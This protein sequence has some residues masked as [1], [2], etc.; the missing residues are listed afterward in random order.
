MEF[1]SYLNSQQLQAVT[2]TDGPMLILA[3]AGSG[4]TRVITYKIAYLIAK[5]LAKPEEIL[6]LTFTNKAAQ[7]MKERACSLL[8]GEMKPPWIS[9]FHALGARLLRLHIDKL[10]QS[11]TNNFT[12]YNEADQVS[13]LKEC[14]QE[15]GSDAK[16][17]KLS[18]LRSKISNIKMNL[19]QKKDSKSMSSAS[20]LDEKIMEIF[21][22]YQQ[23][24]QRYNALD[25][26]DLLLKTF[27]LLNKVKNIRGY[28]QKKFRYV[29]VD[30]FQDT[31]QL[32]YAMLKILVD[33]W[34]NICVVG[35][36]D[37]SIY[38]WRG[39]YI[40]NMFNFAKDFPGCKEIKL[41][42]NYRSTK[43]ILYIA[44]EVIAKNTLRKDKNLW[45]EREEGERAWIYLTEDEDEEARIVVDKIVSLKREY[46]LQEIAVLY[47]TNF[48]SRPFEQAL[49]RLHLPY[50]MVGSIRFFERK[51]IKDILSYFN[52]VAEPADHV[53][54]KRIINVPPRGI[55]GKTLS[56]LEQYAEEH[57]LSLWEAI[58]ADIK[59]IKLAQN[60]RDSL[61]SLHALIEKLRSKLDKLPASR[62]LR[63]IIEET[64]YLS[65]FS[66]ENEKSQQNRLENLKELIAAAKNYEEREE[67]ASIQG[68]LDQ[69]HLTTDQDYY[70][71]TPTVS[72]MTLHCA[73]GLEFSA[74]FLVGMVEG[75]FPH[76]LN[77]NDPELLEEERRLCYVGMTRAKDKLFISTY[78]RRREY[79]TYRNCTPSRFLVDI[80]SQL[81]ERKDIYD[82]QEVDTASRSEI[83]ESIDNIQNFFEVDEFKTDIKQVA[84]IDAEANGLVEGCEVVHPKYG[85]GVLFARSGS[86]DSAKVSVYFPQ[87]GKKKFLLKYAPL[88][89][90]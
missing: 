89:K 90:A 62:L 35:D 41:Q 83:H 34:R 58:S 45:T 49:Q 28:Y 53:S 79:D 37:Q 27:E 40:G 55:G 56:R 78:L 47:R 48:Q 81:I 84:D 13:L 65:T 51:E 33:R 12:I 85:K 71:D 24:L 70:N 25:F 11:L 52:L 86:G 16:S 61:R 26:D 73:K 6:A 50:K 64:N 74:V 72:L 21:Q 88:K 18:S 23:K 54:L 69:V 80:P 57:N 20:P 44:N 46:P 30:E 43:N 1:L 76:R 59:G 17:F 68:F 19:M 8:A 3:G 38:R 2:Q 14:L 87:V 7:E 67:G 36:D 15:L 32:Q 66:S 10:K 9:T 60:V 82:I 77:M 42:Q 63:V 22:L 31:N 39:A 5:N 75:L 4:K 29:L